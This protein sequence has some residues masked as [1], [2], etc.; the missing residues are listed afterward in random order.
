MQLLTSLP[1]NAEPADPGFLA[2]LRWCRTRDLVSAA[3]AGLPDEILVCPNM[4]GRAREVSLPRHEHVFDAAGAAAAPVRGHSGPGNV[5]GAGQLLAAAD[6]ENLGVARGSRGVEELRRVE[7]DDTSPEGRQVEFVD[8]EPGLLDGFGAGPVIPHRYRGQMSHD[9]D[10]VPVEVRAAVKPLCVGLLLGRDVGETVPDPRHRAA[11]RAHWNWPQ[12]G[13]RLRRQ[14]FDIESTP[15]RV[16]I[17]GGDDVASRGRT[18]RG[19][20]ERF[21]VIDHSLLP[22]LGWE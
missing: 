17:D 15:G 19:D 7:L 14:R 1:D 11:D 20:G 21:E 6:R 9:E 2:V 16:F 4:Q 22:R 5:R 12:A 8:H 13:Q 18:G 3:W 10:P